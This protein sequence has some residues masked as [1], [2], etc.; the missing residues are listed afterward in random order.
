[1]NPNSSVILCSGIPWDNTYT[2]LRKFSS[3]SEQ[4][5]YFRARHAY[6]AINYSYV[7]ENNRMG[8]KIDQKQSLID[9][10]NYVCYTNEGESHWHFG[11][12]TSI[13]Y[14]NEDCSVVMFE[15]DWYQTW[16]FHLNA[17]PCF[18]ER[19]TVASDNIGEHIIAEGIDPG[20]LIADY[21]NTRTITKNHYYVYASNVSARTEQNL[22]DYPGERPRIVKPNEYL[23]DGVTLNESACYIIDAGNSS[24]YIEYITNAF[25]KGGQ[26]DSIVGVYNIPEKDVA[27]EDTTEGFAPFPNRPQSYS[28]YIPKNKKLLTYPYMYLR[29][30][31][32][33]ASGEYAFEDFSDSTGNIPRFALVTPT[34]VGS[35]GYLYP[36]GYK[37]GGGKFDP[38]YAMTIN[39]LYQPA[40]SS[41]SFSNF[42]ANHG[43]STALG[44]VS[45]A[46]NIFTSVR[47]IQA[48][49]AMKDY[50]KGEQPL[51]DANY[52]YRL[53]GHINSIADS[54]ISVE[55]TVENLA[56]HSANRNQIGATQ[57]CAAI[58]NRNG[59]VINFAIMRPKKEYAEIIDNY[60][61]LYGYKVNRFGELNID[62]RPAWNYIKTNNVSVYGQAPNDA[63][64]SYANALNRGV[65]FW[66]T[67]DVGNYSLDNSI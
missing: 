11:F 38:N 60:F 35:N 54:V 25:S 42:M 57:S 52:N 64:R 1:M 15:E 39:D 29:V 34:I 56:E 17:H 66:H 33:G 65:T 8:L 27:M 36:V 6:S 3:P 23:S 51:K 13:I 10:C 2:H 61:S 40:W 50:G 53:A 24:N 20:D 44:F 19:E 47:G 26:K 31:I 30:A 62:S 41:D 49:G 5:D 58:M 14:L 28:D 22:G 21:R 45:S 63:I 48:A 37:M 43:I 32:P 4:I 46:L 12:I 9:G 59:L 7:R 67:N 16:M 18:I 55:S